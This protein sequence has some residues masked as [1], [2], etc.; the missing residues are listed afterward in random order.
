MHIKIFLYQCRD[1][2]KKCIDRRHFGEGR[3][4]KLIAHGNTQ[5]IR[6]TTGHTDSIPIVREDFFVAELIL[7]AIPSA[8]IGAERMRSLRLCGA[9]EAIISAQIL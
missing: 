8:D 6:Q 3:H 5:R 7:L 9:V 2:G 4:I 1:C